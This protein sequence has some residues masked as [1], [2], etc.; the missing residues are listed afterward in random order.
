VRQV[1]E[2]LNLL[3]RGYIEFEKGDCVRMG[4]QESF[5]VN[6]LIA[7][8]EGQTT[9]ADMIDARVPADVITPIGDTPLI[10]ATYALDGE[11]LKATVRARYPP[12]SIP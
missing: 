8:L 7:H 5:T 10:Y 12:V 9:L 4:E 1:H 3:L 11:R 2:M 6:D